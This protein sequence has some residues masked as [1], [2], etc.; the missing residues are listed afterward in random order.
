MAWR[1]YLFTIG[2]AILAALIVRHWV[3]TAYKV[4]TGSMQPA[5]KPGDFIFSTRWSYGIRV[6]FGGGRSW[7]EQMPHR[8]DVVVFSYPNQPDTNYVKRI[9]AIPG[10]RVQIARN[11]LILNGQSLHY[12]KSESLSENPNPEIFEMLEESDGEHRRTL[13]F[14]KGSQGKDFGPI[15]VPPGE[16]FLLGDNRD[17]SDDSRY[18]GTVPVSQIHGKVSWIWLSLDWQQKWGDNRFPH[19]RWQRIF[20]PV[21]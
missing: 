14:E 18:W 8:G 16:V 9:I 7:A 15:V 2:A 1:Q 20:V 13:I 17:A 10:D 3:L 19:L 21:D 6:P 12:Q 4:P 11:H 5:L